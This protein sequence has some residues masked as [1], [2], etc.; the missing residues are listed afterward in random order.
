MLYSGH[1]TGSL[2]AMHQ[3]SVLTLLGPNYHLLKTA[4]GAVWKGYQERQLFNLEEMSK[5]TKSP[6]LTLVVF[7]RKITVIKVVVLV[8]FSKSYSDFLALLH[9]SCL[10]QKYFP[11]NLN[12]CVFH[13]NILFYF[14]GL[15]H[16][17]RHIQSFR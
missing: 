17:Q 5:I 3:G 1:L 10:F 12:T 13:L 14:A 8:T 15:K 6:V 2:S 4:L 9:K 16:Q 7:L 11:P